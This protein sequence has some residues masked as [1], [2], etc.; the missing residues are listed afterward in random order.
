MNERPLPDNEREW[1]MRRLEYKWIVALVYVLALFMTLLDQTIT[2]VAL[3]T[4]ARVFHASATDV[5]WVATSYLLSAAVCIPISGWFGDRFG[6]KRTFALALVIFTVGSFACGLANST[7][8]LVAFRVL[9]GIGGGLLTPV[10]ATVLLRAFSLSERARVASLITIPAVAAP[11]LGPV[12]GGYLVEFQ[13]WRWIFLIN[14]PLGI[15]GLAI[16]FTSL[17]EQRAEGV[18][19]LDLPG[20]ALAAAGLAAFVYG[21]SEVGARGFGD[22]QVR[23]FGLIGIAL[24]ALFVVVELRVARPLIDVRLFREPLF[25]ASNGVLFFIQ[26]GF[27]GVTFLLPQLLQAERGLSP[28]AA[29]LVGCTTAIGIIAGSPLVGRLYPT[30]GP[31]RLI[32]GG[33]A[34]AALAALSLR[35]VGLTTDPWL[36]RG[37]VFVLGVAFGFVF[38]PLQTASFAR[39]S[40]A[41]TG[42]ASAAY[43][44]VRQV[45]TSIGVA[46]LATV[47]SSRLVVYGATLGNPGTR[48]GALNAFHD[49]F[50]AAA[51]LDLLGLAAALLISDRLAASTMKRKTADAQTAPASPASLPVLVD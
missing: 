25:A 26:G 5:A 10:G 42:R 36:I 50:A 39:I 18:G 40:P 51:L 46:L 9:Q 21:L 33:M 41:Q 11:A 28:L 3:P 13:T 15:I 43:S 34:L 14:V 49:A 47:L 37:Q 8:S 6:T 32:M 20:F 16:A 30:V 22:A 31:R 35:L 27:F 12:V 4:L 17:R 44:A 2:N 1:A 45:A 38:V 23:A 29:G 19:P 48:P 7:G 24:L